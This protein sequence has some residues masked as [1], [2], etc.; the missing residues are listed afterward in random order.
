MATRGKSLTGS[1]P[2]LLPL[3]VRTCFVTFQLTH[4]LAGGVQRADIASNEFNH[5][6]NAEAC[7]L[8]DRPD[9]PIHQH[10]S[11]TQGPVAS[12]SS[13]QTVSSAVSNR[14]PPV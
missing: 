2:T 14:G 11:R 1:L 3:L 7:G 6:T 5:E 12:S 13:W 4:R 8:F 9:D 10:D